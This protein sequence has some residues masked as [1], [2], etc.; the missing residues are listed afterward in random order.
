MEAS[1]TAVKISS[2]Q[3]GII[4][5]GTSIQNINIVL[6]LALKSLKDVQ[7]NSRLETF[8]LLSH[9]VQIKALKIPVPLL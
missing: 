5:Q 4:N 3:G 6:D 7:K 2:E 1:S 8:V 9:D